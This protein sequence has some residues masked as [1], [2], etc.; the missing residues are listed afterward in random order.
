MVICSALIVVCLT[1][2]SGQPTEKSPYLDVPELQGVELYMDQTVYPRDVEEITFY[3][4]NN[5]GEEFLYG[6]DWE[7]EML[8][9]DEWYRV[10]ARMSYSVASVAHITKPGAVHEI[11]SNLYIYKKPLKKGNY[12]FIQYD[13][14]TKKV[15]VI[16]FQ[17]E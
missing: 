4:K 10:D 12:R 5:T 15:I 16:E 17:I 6:N 2:C 7:L 14:L 11:T 13:Y 9:K 8:Y 1:G 3:L